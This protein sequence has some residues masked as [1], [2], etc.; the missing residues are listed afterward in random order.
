MFSFPVASQRHAARCSFRPTIEA[1]EA[2]EMMNASPVAPLAQPGGGANAPANYVRELPP[3]TINIEMPAYVFN[4]SARAA[5]VAAAPRGA[6]EAAK[7][8]SF[9]D[10]FNQPA[11]TPS[12]NKNWYLDHNNLK[13]NNNNNVNY[14]NTK[15][16]LRVVDD[17]AASDGKALA[18]TIKK[19]GKDN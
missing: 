15:R 6:E 1:L 17:P 9:S 7:T 19:V 14:T 13:D 18:L 2:R 11:G 5:G 16:T 4:A 3:A 10:D 8:P 12:S